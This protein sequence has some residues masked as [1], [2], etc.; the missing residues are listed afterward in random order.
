[1][2]VAQLNRPSGIAFT[3]DGTTV[4]FTEQV[5]CLLVQSMRR[6]NSVRR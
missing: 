6:G 1:M 3:P 5:R 4:L 2:A